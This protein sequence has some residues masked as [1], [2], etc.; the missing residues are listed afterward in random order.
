MYYTEVFLFREGQR[1]GAHEAKVKQGAK[2]EEKKGKGSELRGFDMRMIGKLSKMFS[3][4]K[5]YINY[6]SVYG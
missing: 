3:P 6:L 4:R 5:V 2:W 1:T